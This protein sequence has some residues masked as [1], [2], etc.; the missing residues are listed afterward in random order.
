MR[1]RLTYSQS[2]RLED[3]LMYGISTIPLRLKLTRQPRIPELAS[4]SLGK[5]L[6]LLFGQRQ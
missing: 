4:E 2:M 1:L 3:I 5:L 6:S